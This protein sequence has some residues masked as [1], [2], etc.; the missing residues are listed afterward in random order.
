[1]RQILTVHEDCT[2]IGNQNSK[3]FVKFSELLDQSV[4]NGS[5]SSE[6]H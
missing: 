6:M 3:Q 5:V 1:M 4:V 2:K